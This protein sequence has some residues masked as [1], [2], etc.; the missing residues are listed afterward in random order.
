MVYAGRSFAADALTV[1][2]STTLNAMPA[3][4]T[5]S[6]NTSSSCAFSGLVIWSICNRR[7]GM[8]LRA[9]V[10][11]HLTYVFVLKERI[12]ARHMLAC[13]HAQGRHAHLSF[14]TASQ[15]K[16]PYLE[17]CLLGPSKSGLRGLAGA[18]LHC[19]VLAH[20][21]LHVGCAVLLCCLGSCIHC[22]GRAGAA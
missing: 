7:K 18:P 16:H 12:V 2:F 21:F 3:S 10:R 4:M 22:C 9:Y 19:L 6:M 8:A 17:R 11:H 20:S 15:I 5:I 1:L 14:I 13:V